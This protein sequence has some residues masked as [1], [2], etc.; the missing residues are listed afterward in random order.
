MKNILLIILLTLTICSCSFSQEATV[1]LEWDQYTQ[2][3]SVRVYE[4][5]ELLSVKN[6]LITVSNTDSTYEFDVILDG[7]TH[8]FAVAGWQSNINYE[9][10]LSNNI[11]VTYIQS[12]AN[13]RGWLKKKE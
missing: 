13:F 4:V 1:H 5:N 9:S 11:T 12:P 2:A 10:E 6:L 8:E 3:D 7:K